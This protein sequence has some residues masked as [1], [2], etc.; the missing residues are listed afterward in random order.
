[1]K[2]IVSITR[3]GQITIPTEMRRRLGVEGQSQAIIELVGS[4]LVI[5]PR[6]D[7]WSLAGSL[8][9]PVKLTDAQLK[10]A[11]KQFAKDWARK[12]ESE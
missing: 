12:E 6:S 5:E 4:K 10:K 1:M 7:F 2:S 11:R 9:S 3:Q 8:A